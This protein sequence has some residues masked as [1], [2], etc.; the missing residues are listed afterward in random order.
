MKLR[1]A[2]LA[3]AALLASG[4][5]FAQV[6]EGTV[7]IEPFVGYFWGG[8]FPR[9]STAIFPFEVDVEDDLTYGGRIGYNVTS[10]FEIEALFQRTQSH[11]V[12]NEDSG[13]VFGGDDEVRLGNLDIDYWMGYSTFN[14]GHGRAVPYVTFGAGVAVLDPEVPGVPASSDTRFTASIGGGVKIFFTPHF[15]MKFDGRY[16]G[17]LLN[18]DDFCDGD[19]CHGDDTNWLSAGSATGGLVFAF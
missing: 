12:T 15:G 10:L 16:F 7:E 3:A 2:S 19:R 8:S 13:P 14:F 17:T 11:F 6:R 4:G 1:I 9:G 18:E 5:L